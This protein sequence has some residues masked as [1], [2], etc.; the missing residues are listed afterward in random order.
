MSR[1]FFRLS[2]FV[3]LALTLVGCTVAPASTLTP[4]I[5]SAAGTFSPGLQTQIAGTGTALHLTARANTPTPAP[6][7]VVS[8]A[9]PPPAPSSSTT[10]VANGYTYALA[11]E[12][13]IGAYTARWWQRE[14]A[15][16]C[17]LGLAT[18]EK[19]GQVMV[20]IED[21]CPFTAL[22]AA[23]ITGEGEPDILFKVWHAGSSHRCEGLLLF[24]LGA[25][26]VKV[27][28]IVAR[29]YMYDGAG[30]FED[31]DGDGRYEFI[32]RDGYGYDGLP[33]SGPTVKAIARYDPAQQTYTGASPRFAGQYADEVTRSLQRAESSLK[34]TESGY[35]CDVAQMVAELLYS[36]QAE[37]A[38]AEFDR[39]Y[40]GPDATEFRAALEA[41]IRRGRFF[42]ER[43]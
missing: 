34:E 24:N 3:A 30:V 29:P 17:W 42:V 22:P 1:S 9:P 40:L 2:W 13:Q 10:L 23:D 6:L 35:K 32:T 15:G 38:W 25:A 20:T 12:R 28:D 4:T 36:G 7:V 39:L 37:R 19:A 27:L 26:P 31:S 16:L 21:A 41:G 5:A 8:D 14:N 43:P 18:L 11:D 33:C